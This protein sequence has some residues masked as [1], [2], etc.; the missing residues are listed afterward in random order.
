MMR[1][2]AL[3]EMLAADLQPVR[4]VPSPGRSLLIWL[5]VTIPSLALITLIMGLR[6]SL[7]ARPGFVLDQ[8]LALSTAL[9]AAYG[10]VCAGRPD[11][12][13]W[14]LGLPVALMVL[15]FGV[16]CGQC[17]LMSLGGRPD[18]LVLQADIVCVPAIAVAGLLPAITMVLLLRFSPDFRRNHA[19]LCGAMAAAAAAEFT[20][21]LFHAEG[22]FLTLLVWQMGS[23]M[24]LT[25]SG[26][27]IGR[28]VLAH[29]PVRA[30]RPSLSA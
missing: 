30:A 17:L 1:D 26:S 21:R 6:P 4:R 28:W 5:A 15:W 7:S 19:C 12:P 10:A 25:I 9:S 3:I 8:I 11:Q 16:L 13:S 18:A 29:R 20:L 24:L 14:K 23:V 27:L 2:D 22:S